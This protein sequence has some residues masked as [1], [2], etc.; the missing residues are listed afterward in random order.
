MYVPLAKATLKTGELLEVGVVV[1]PDED[2][3]N[4]I[5]SFLAHKPANFR[6]HIDRALAEPLDE[7]ETRFYLGELQGKI[8]T[9]VMTVEHRGVGI[10][11]HVFTRPDHRLKGACRAVMQEQMADFLHR[12]GKVL[13]LG[14]GFETPPYWIY[15]RFGFRSIDGHSGFMKY[16]AEAGFEEAF[17]A[18]APVQV[19]EVAWHHWPT[20]NLLCAQEEGD[21]VRSIAFG[22]FGR[23]NF[24]GGF[25]RFK[26]SLEENP[27]HQARLLASET[28]AI[29]G[30]ATVQPD[31]R[32]R[33]QV[34]LLDLFLHPH[35]AREATRLL[36]ALSL[37]EGKIQ[38]Y[39]EPAAEAV[40]AALEQAGFKREALLRRQVRR[41]DQWLDVAV[42]AR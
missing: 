28:G 26:Q 22:H 2:Y 7:L 14:T 16:C 6:W 42:Y 34:A 15:Y 29:V 35:F 38:S 11:G 4:R 33:G 40:I 13:T 21:Y 17:F 10:L 41:E 31:S 18:A 5:R 23:A 32:W 25:L 24:E 19:V 20:L 1:A 39:V 9:N 8:I 12:G 3:A 36:K 30:Y 27:A 37:P